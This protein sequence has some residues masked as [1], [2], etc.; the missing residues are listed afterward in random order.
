VAPADAAK[1]LNGRCTVEFVVRV[2]NV[3]PSTPPIGFLNSEADFRSPA[4]FTAVVFDEGL[5]KFTAAG[6]TDFAGH[7]QGKKIRVTGQVT[8][9]RERLQIVVADPKQIE[10]VP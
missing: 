7:F 6:I 5:Q 2:A 9:R 10:I 4:N 3:Q 8:E 1:H